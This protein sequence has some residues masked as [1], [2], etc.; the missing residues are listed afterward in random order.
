MTE[1]ETSKGNRQRTTV[2]VGST[3]INMEIIESE[4][5]PS[6]F[7]A[8]DAMVFVFSMLSLATFDS[9][10]AYKNIMTTSH[11]RC[12]IALIGTM[13]DLSP[14]KV[15]YEAG[16]RLA[17]D[18]Q[19]GYFLIS[20]RDTR[21][22]DAVFEYLLGRYIYLQK[23][24]KSPEALEPPDSCWLTLHIPNWIRTKLCLGE[25]RKA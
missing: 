24:L 17:Q 15:Q 2:T 20:N 16:L 8:C 7:A 21:K 23:A 22:I 11:S 6:D 18:L 10:Q 4:S 5:G 14:Q 25:R 1:A 19:A 9:V 12:L 3:L 13:T